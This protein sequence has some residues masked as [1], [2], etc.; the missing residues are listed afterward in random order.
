MVISLVDQ[1]YVGFQEGSAL[2]TPSADYEW[3]YFNLLGGSGTEDKVY[4]CAKGEDDLYNWI[5][6]SKGEVN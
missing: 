2:P 1:P 5:L 3:V 4:F 6:I